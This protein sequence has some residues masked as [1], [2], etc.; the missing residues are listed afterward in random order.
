MRIQIIVVL[1]L[2]LATACARPLPAGSPLQADTSASLAGVPR[3]ESSACPIQIPAGA[4]VECGYLFVPENRTRPDSPT[5]RLAVAIL[6][7]RSENPAPDP[8][9]Y[10]AGG[11]GASALSEEPLGWWLDSPFLDNRNFILFE[12]RGTRYSDPFL[13]C[14][15]THIATIL[16]PGGDNGP[17]LN[18]VLQ[19]RDRLLRQGVDLTAYNSVA[20]AA[21]LEDLRTALGYAEWNLY[22]VS[23]GTQLALT[24]MRDTPAGIRSVILDSTIPL[25]ANISDVLSN[26]ASGLDVLFTA[27]TANPECHTAFPNLETAFYRVLRRMNAHPVLVSIHAPPYQVLVTGDLLSEGI[28]EALQSA[29]TIPLLPLLI[30]QFDRGNIDVLTS[31]VDS[32]LQGNNDDFGLGMGFSVDCYEDLHFTDAQALAAAVESYPDLPLPFKTRDLAVCP[33]WGAGKSGP[34]ENEPVYSDIPTLILAGQHDPN[35]TPSQGRLAAETL[36]HSYFFEFPGLGHMVTEAGDPSNCP[37]N[38]AASFVDNPSA[39]PDTRCIAQM[40]GIQYITTDDVYITPIVYRMLND[41]LINSNPFCL[42]L[43]AICLFLFVAEVLLLPVRLI[44]RRK[45]LSL[46]RP[47]AR[48]ARGVAVATA[49]LNL[50]FL[51]GLALVIRGVLSTNELVLAVGLPAQ[52][53]PLFLIPSLVAILAVGLIV[54]SV[55]AWK[56]RYWSLVGRV[57]YSLFT[58]GVLAFVLLLGYWRL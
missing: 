8:I 45:K 28:Y 20:S 2:S 40:T 48:M 3:F 35:T 51:I 46:S 23:Y 17:Y 22:G 14:P 26:Y 10:L 7:S 42:G 11:P 9:V 13:N 52:A 34:I 50:V 47:M 36:S 29:Q 25:Q 5:I 57:H 55:L 44:R 21:D 32:N 39:A 24:A 53:R 4:K 49:V 6:K 41:L 27:C 54:L 37:L 19:C 56:D 1:F 12:Q 15:E 31:V 16:D 30:D 43:L 38:V 18:E 33:I 58:L